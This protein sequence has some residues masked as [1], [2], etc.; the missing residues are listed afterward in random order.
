MLAAAFLLL[1]CRAQTLP[2]LAKENAFAE[3]I[4]ISSA[5][6]QPSKT[7]LLQRISVT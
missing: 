6:E 4:F 2:P 1:P 5:V 7:G 3:L